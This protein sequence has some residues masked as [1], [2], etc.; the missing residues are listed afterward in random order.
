MCN[1][2]FTR[3]HRIPQIKQNAAGRILLRRHINRPKNALITSYQYFLSQTRLFSSR[4]RRQLPSSLSASESH[5]IV[6]LSRVACGLYRRWGFSPRLKEHRSYAIVTLWVCRVNRQSSPQRASPPRARQPRRVLRR[7][8]PQSQRQRCP[9]QRDSPPYADGVPA[10]P[11][12][13][14][15]P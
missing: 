2:A 13:S 4:L 3:E 15:P 11:Q 7:T 8:P 14:S 6:P 5:R 12:G 10:S 9:R 1:E